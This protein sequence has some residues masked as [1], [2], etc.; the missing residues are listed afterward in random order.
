MSNLVE[1]YLMT[2]MNEGISTVTPN[3]LAAS[4]ICDSDRPNIKMQ[5]T[6]AKDSSITKASPSF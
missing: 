5:K 2:S 3:S 4:P 1:A 6:G